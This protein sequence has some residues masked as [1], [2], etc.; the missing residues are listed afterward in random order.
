MHNG[1]STG[2]YYERLDHVRALAVFL[3][4]CWHVIHLRGAVPVAH[5]PWMPLLSLIEEGHIGVGIFMVLS[6]YLFAKIINGQ[7]INVRAFW[8]NRALRLLP[9]L[10]FAL[11]LNYGLA[12]MQGS[13]T[14]YQIWSSFFRGFLLPAWPNVAWSVTVELH[15]YLILPLLLPIAWKRPQALILLIAA[16]LYVRTSLYMNGDDI[17]RVSYWTII[18]RMD[19][20]LCGILAFVLTRE[21]RITLLPPIAVC[22]ALIAYWHWFNIQGG[23]YG[24]KGSPIWIVS[25]VIEGMM[26]GYLIS[27]YD[28]SGIVLP[29]LIGQSLVLVGTLSYS[30]YLLHF[31]AIQNLIRPHVISGEIDIK[32][33]GAAF[34]FTVVLFIVFLPIAYLSYRLI[35]KPFL[36]MRIPYIARSESS[37]KD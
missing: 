33:F 23:Y 16:M 27:A 36:R 8:F 12:W 31:P 20:F 17:R 26:I 30:I 19:Q 9:L 21:R 3:V 25:P 35:E 18:G 4:F 6:G 2:K 22:I 7:P 24:T 34:G 15:F 28:R 29:R 5:V 14:G 37:F 1:S 11:A 13:Q 32:T 10:L